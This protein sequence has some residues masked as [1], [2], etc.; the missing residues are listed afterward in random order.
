MLLAGVLFAIAIASGHAFAQAHKDDADEREWPMGG[1]NLANTRSQDR[2][3]ALSAT[4]APRLALKWSQAMHGDVSA[5][6]AVVH[7]AV[8]VPDW[9]GCLTKFDARTGAILWRRRIDSYAGEPS[10]AISRTSPAVANG[11]LYIGDVNDGHLLAID[12]NTGNLLWSQVINPGPFAIVT[13]SPVV[14]DDV[15]YVGASSAE[16]GNVAFMPGYACCRFQGSF[17]AI[18]AKTGKIKWSTKTVPDNHGKA[19]GY[20]GGAVWSS[21]PALDVRSR[22]IFIT[23]GNNYSMPASA[24]ACSQNG[25]TPAQCL[26]PDDHIDSILALDM[27]TGRVKWSTGVQGFDN[28]TFACLGLP[29]SIAANCPPSPGHDFDFGA[30]ANLLRIKRADGAERLVVGAGQKSGIYW[31]LDANDGKILWATRVTPGSNLGGILWGTATDGK[32]VYV[33]SSDYAG[34]PYTIGGAQVTTGSFAALDAVTGHILWQRAD[35]SDNPSRLDMAAASVTNGVMFAGSMSGHMYALDAASGELL[36]DYPGAGSSSSGPA[37]G[38]DGTVYW[39]N[40]YSRQGS[41]GMMF[42]AFSVPGR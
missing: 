12:A 26:D 18:N 32:R 25:G 1:Q 38:E 21:T 31:M 24:V 11:V 4:N 6:P 30:G 15:V 14:H 20:S 5:T 23:T 17:S 33:E 35:A 39:G 36:W 16:E 8:Y 2:Q 42:Y 7:H 41:A 9:G 19:G 28:W 27:D 3:T 34:T 13:Q 40:G 22:T 10:G 29:G 37:I